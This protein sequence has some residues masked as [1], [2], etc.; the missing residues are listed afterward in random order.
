MNGNVTVSTKSAILLL[1]NLE[2]FWQFL[3]QNNPKSGH[4]KSTLLLLLCREYFALGTVFVFSLNLNFFE[5]LR[6]KS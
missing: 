1:V 4:G 3:K 5:L 6:K 2:G